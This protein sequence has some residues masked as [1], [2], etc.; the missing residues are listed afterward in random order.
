[1]R[2]QPS[3]RGAVWSRAWRDHRADVGLKGTVQSEWLWTTLHSAASPSLWCPCQPL[4]QAPPQSPPS[5]PGAVRRARSAGSE[6]RQR[7]ELVTGGGE[8]LHTAHD[9]GPG[10]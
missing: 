6:R 2:S 7:G 9:A 5:I 8:G 1:L 3:A 4:V 10:A